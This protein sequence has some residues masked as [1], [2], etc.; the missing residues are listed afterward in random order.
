MKNIFIILILPFL[1]V[2]CFDKKNEAQVPIS[3]VFE[4]AQDIKIPKNLMLEIEN[5]L[6]EDSKLIAPVYV[7]IPLQVELHEK[8]PGVL[9]NNPT[10]ILFPKGGG[11]LDLKNVMAGSG[12]FYLNFPEEQ[13]AKIPDLLHLYYISQSP[14]KTIDQEKFGLGCGKYVDLK[15][16]FKSLQKKEYFKLNTTELRHL[17]VLAGHYVFV[18]R[19]KNQV[20]LAQMTITDSRYASDLCFSKAGVQE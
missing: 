8:S 15:K 3:Q 20:Y 9:K 2:A 10:K 19:D 11:R 16:K 18:F 17:F 7:F 12:T 1:L 6:A 14:V 4:V 5:E 13:F